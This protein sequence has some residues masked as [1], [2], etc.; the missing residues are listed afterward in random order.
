LFFAE[1][2]VG[3]L[4]AKKSTWQVFFDRDPISGSIYYVLICLFLMMPALLRIGIKK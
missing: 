4:I 1:L 2:M 3:V